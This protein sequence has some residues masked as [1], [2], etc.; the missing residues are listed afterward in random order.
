MDINFR[1]DDRFKL[2]LTNTLEMEELELDVSARH[3]VALRVASCRCGK[4]E[5][6]ILVILG[7]PPYSG[8]SNQYWGLDFKGNKGLL[9]G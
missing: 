2:Y 6:P 1:K 9:S 7:N 3:G 5:Q 8:H 4:K